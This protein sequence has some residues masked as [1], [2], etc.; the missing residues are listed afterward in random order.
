LETGNIISKRMKAVKSSGSKIEV[1]LAKALWH[2]GFRYRKN[3]PS[4]FGK[5]DIVFKKIKVAVFVDSEF[6]HG[7]DWEIRKFDHK[8][9]IDYWIKKIERNIQRDIEVNQVLEELGWKVMR[10]WGEDVEKK[11]LLCIEKIEIVANERKFN[12]KSPTKI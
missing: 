7:K 10:F 4:V 11:L 3:D 12:P 1:K 6:W 9:N 5:P 2:R 8:S